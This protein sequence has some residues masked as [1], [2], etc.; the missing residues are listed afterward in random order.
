M[1]C[2]HIAHSSSQNKK[3]K[4]LNC[5]KI[6]NYAP[7]YYSYRAKVYGPAVPS[8]C[9]GSYISLPLTLQLKS[10]Q[11]FL[12]FESSARQLWRFSE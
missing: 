5:I 7:F 1:I 3:K 12:K 4:T 11:D 2:Y 10:K 8:G 6:P 9:G